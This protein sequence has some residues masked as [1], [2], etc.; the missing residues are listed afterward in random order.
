MNHRNFR[1]RRKLSQTSEFKTLLTVIR[2]RQIH[3]GTGGSKKA[4]REEAGKQPWRRGH[5][6]AEDGQVWRVH[7]TQPTGQVWPSAC[8][9]K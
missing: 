8:F 2:S 5:R 3:M 6:H 7:K 4:V 9:C 1:G